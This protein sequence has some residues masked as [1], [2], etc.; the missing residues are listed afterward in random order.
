MNGLN[1]E[2]KKAVD[3]SSIFSISD[4]D[5]NILYA[6]RQFLKVSGYTL[7]ELIGKPHSIVRH[8]DMD[9]TVFKN[10]WETIQDKKVWQG[11]VKN[12]RKNG[13]AYYVDVT[14]VPIL[15]KNNK[16]V[17]YAG[18]RHDITELVSKT[19]E[20]STLKD[21][22]RAKDIQKAL[23]IKT[24]DI[25]ESIPF[26][27]ILVEE[28]SLK[29]ISYNE[30]FNSTFADHPCFL[31]D[32]STLEKLFIQEEPY[33]LSNTLL[34]FYNS[35]ELCSEDEKVVAINIHET[36]YEYSIGMTQKNDSLIITL[37]EKK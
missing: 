35:Y 29:I 25:L 1:N 4:L 19:E 26:A 21:K 18:I 20:L 33:L 14:I 7:E 16:I 17:E 3:A 9:K 36:I 22:Q 6:N 34:S 37:V 30:L 10:L 15:D 32:E 13:E 2:Y 27:S 28:D 31:D 5:G 12:K 24:D 11:T 23:S 8:P